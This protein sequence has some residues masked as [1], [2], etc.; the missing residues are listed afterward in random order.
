MHKG[1]VLAGTIRAASGV[2]FLVAPLQAQR[3]WSQRE[4]D[5]PT[6]RVLLRSMGYR[7]ALIGGGLLAAGLTDSPNVG[8]WFLASAGADTADLIGELANQEHLKSPR[9]QVM[10]M[11]GAALGIVIGLG[12]WLTNRSPG[13]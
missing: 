3:L 6:A 2:S 11:G 8:R 12:G 9:D 1:A 5:D 7:D 10:G 4:A 13:K